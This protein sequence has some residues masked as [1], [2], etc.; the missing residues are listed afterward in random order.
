MKLFSQLSILLMTACC[1][2]YHTITLSN[3]GTLYSFGKKCTRTTWVRA[4]QLC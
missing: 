4:Q 3:N 2:A 1:G